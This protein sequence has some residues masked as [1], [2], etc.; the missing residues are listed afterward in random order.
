MPRLWSA[1]GTTDPMADVMRRAYSLLSRI[2][3]GGRGARAVAAIGI[4]F[5]ALTVP[6]G[7]VH[8]AEVAGV[9]IEPGA[10]VA[11]VDLALNG[12]GLR[13][14]FLADVYVIGMYFS[15]RTTSAET[16]IDSTGP[17][18]IALTFMRDVTAESLVEALYEG[19]RDSSGAT[20]F[21]SLKASADALSAIM[22]PLRIAKKGDI[23]ALDYVPDAG[24][25]VVVNGRAVGRPVPDRN[26][27]RALLR[28][29]L[30]DAPVD[31]KLKRALLS[32]RT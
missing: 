6:G 24:A 19:V 17:K 10:R 20:E 13:K 26:L 23:V 31:A 29:W 18:R 16:A 11:G 28:I 25:Q 27:Y 1:D 21:T 12:A 8:A 32:G 14:L 4:V 15:E 22:L 2:R 30:G 5:A 9:R 3:I 7:M